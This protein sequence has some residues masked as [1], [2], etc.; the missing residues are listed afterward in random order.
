MSAH[1]PDRNAMPAVG[2]VGLGVMGLPMAQNLVSA[3]YP[4]TV[5]TRTRARAESLL[6]AGSQWAASPAAVADASDVVITM[7]PDSTD[8][9]DV[10]HG[11]EGLLAGA[12][13]DVTWIDMSSI[14]PAVTTM[15]AREAAEHGVDCLDA[16]VSGGEQGAIDGTLSIMVG[17][18]RQVFDRC[19]PIL[20]TLGAS[21]VHVGD[22]GAGQVTKL[23]NQM[24]VG[25]TIA[26]VAE[27]LVLADKSGVDPAAVRQVLLGGFAQS[28]ILDVHGQRML[29][30]SFRPGFRSALH[31]KDLAN[32]LDAAR[33]AAS[34]SPLTAI[35][36]QLLTALQA[37]GGGDLDHSA[38]VQVYEALAGD[39]NHSPG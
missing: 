29:D 28:K 34:P 5:T 32:A 26:A 30:R 15:L 6:D 1:E 21:V 9:I 8:V 39:P 17:G 22:T 13:A 14:A 7:L 10:A 24:I 37:A 16:P 3:G 4:L 23:C 11:S 33:Q 35:V 27:A 36:M 20:Q 18:P 25:T 38:L 31:Q 2:F 12:R 19:L